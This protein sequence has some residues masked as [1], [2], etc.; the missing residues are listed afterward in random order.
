[1]S[2]VISSDITVMVITFD[3]APNIRRCLDSVKWASRI[4]IVDSG[5]SDET[6]DIVSDYPHA[7]VVTRQFD[8]FADQC[9][10]G[11][12]QVTTPW[13]LSLDADYRLSDQLINEIR[14]LR[15]ESQAGYSTSFTYC[16]HGRPLR[17]SL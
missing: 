11:L 12:T 4:L 10:F 6:L 7:Y 8:N 3:E 2:E 17:S 9:N 14:S 13:V 16:V 15:P 1:M 5:S